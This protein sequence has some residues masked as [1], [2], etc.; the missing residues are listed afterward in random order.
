M[1]KGNLEDLLQRDWIPQYRK[2]RDAI[3]DDLM[4]LNMNAYVM[5][6]IVGYPLELLWTLKY[7][8]FDI[9]HT[10]LLE[11]SV[12]I[13]FR[14]GLDNRKSNSSERLNLYSFGVGIVANLKSESD[15]GRLKKELEKR[16]KTVEK[17]LQI[18]REVRHNFVGHRSREKSTGRHGEEFLLK[19]EVYRSL[20]MVCDHL[21][22]LF[23][24]LYIERGS[25][26]KAVYPY[27]YFQHGAWQP[28]TNP[29]SGT[30]LDDLFYLIVKNSH[31]LN[32]PEREPGFWPTYRENLSES[33]MKTVNCYRAK[34]DLPP[35]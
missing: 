5:E 20:K 17:D 10:S 31:L 22:C 35:V 26:A 34:L 28:P 8:F 16:K 13:A 33:E 11:S 7:S 27:K 15:K 6:Q 32:M 2:E 30:D 23:D 14:I 3:L 12:S 4:E 1:I 29:D 9:V 21:N 19:K 24:L 25:T 18:I